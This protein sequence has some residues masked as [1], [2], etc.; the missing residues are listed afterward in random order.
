MA[1]NGA[2]SGF[3]VTS[4]RFTAEAITFAQGRNVTLIDGPSLQKLIQ[5]KSRKVGMDSMLRN[6]IIDSVTQ[7]RMLN[8]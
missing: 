4:G 2:A 6:Q 5:H 7:H 1:A 3:V 8:C